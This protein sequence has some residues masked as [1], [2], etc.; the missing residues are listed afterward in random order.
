[1]FAHRLKMHFSL[2]CLLWLR[3]F[4]LLSFQL[5]SEALVM[6]YIINLVS[7]FGSKPSLNKHI[8]NVQILQNF[9]FDIV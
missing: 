5:V 7:E 8:I 3:F 9:V 2:T 4:F 6:C 1:M